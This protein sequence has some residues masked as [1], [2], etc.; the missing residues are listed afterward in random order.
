MRAGFTKLAG[1]TAGRVAALA[2]AWLVW[3]APAADTAR[4]P[5]ANL[6]QYGFL[7]LE[8]REAA[9]G[10]PPG[11]ARLADAA[12]TAAVALEAGDALLV[13]WQHP[14]PVRGLELV[15]TEP[16][17]ADAMQVE[18]WRGHWPDAGQ[19]GWMKLDDPFNGRWTLGQGAFHPH[20]SGLAFRFA[21]LTVRE[22]PGIRQTGAPFRK[23]YKL[24]LTGRQAVRLRRVAVRS[25]AV[26]RH[27][28]LRFE[29]DLPK[30]LPAHAAPRFE[31][32]NGTVQAVT[33]AAAKAAF[34]EV[35]YADAPDRL[36]PDRGLVIFRRGPERS[37][38]VFVDDVL[39]AGGLLVRDLG[40]FVSDAS[41]NLTFATWPGPGGDVWRQG[42]VAEQVAR[43]PEQTFAQAMAA[44]PA[45]PSAPCLLG[46]PNCR[47]EFVLEPDGDIVL[48]AGS[49]RSP[50]P[51]ADA[52]PW[53][54][55]DALRFEFST[56]ERPALN[57]RGTRVVE[58]SLQDGWL[59]V[60]RHAW[61]DDGLAWEQ[62]SVAA[63][64]LTPLAA[65]EA[66]TGAEPLVLGTRFSVTNT[67]AAARTAWLWL[68]PQPWRPLRLGADGT[69]LLVRPSDNV[70]RAGMVPVRGQFVSGGC[71][72]LD[73]GV[74]VPDTPDT[75]SAPPP[76]TS[77][78]REAVRYRV[79]LGPGEGHALDFLLPYVELL[80]A[81][82]MKA[83]RG[84]SFTNLHAAAVD[85]WRARV[86]RG[87][88]LETPEPW[89]ND[90]FKAHLW[91]VL[92]STD[93]DPETHHHQ[94]GAATLDYK[95]FLNETAMV[96]RA[97]DMR[98]EHAAA[99]AL[100][101][102]FLVN[103]G[104][105]GLPGNFRS[106]AGVFY[107][108][109]PGDPDPYTAQGYNLHHGWGLWAAS[110]HY[111]WTRDDAYLAAVTPRLIAGADWITCERQATLFK[112]PG[113]ARPVEYGLPP[114]GDLED[115]E[116]YLYWYAT[117][118][119]YHLGM[120]QAADV[121][122]RLAR[123]PG[124]APELARRLAREAERLRRDTG[125]F[126][127][128]VRA[129]VAES[130]ATSPVIQLR[131]DTWVPHMPARAYALT[132]RQE[133]WIREV[134]YGPLHLVNGDLLDDRHPFVDW[135]V[136][137]LEDNLLLCAESGF[138]VADPQ[139]DFFNHGGF[140]LQPMLLDLA[141]AY[142][143]RDQVPNF[144]RAFYNAAAAS[145]YPDTR[146]LAEWLPE[147]G[148]GGG[149]LYKT[150][151]ESKFIQ[152]LRQMLLFERGDTL[153][154]GL[155]VPRAW[156]ADGQRVKVERA[157]TWFGRLDL[158][159]TSRAAAGEIRAVV[160]LQ[161]TE[162]PRAL[163]LRLRHPAGQPLKSATVNGRSASVNAARQ[164][165]EL[166][167]GATAWEVIGRF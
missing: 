18:W 79:T 122:A 25:D 104:V 58:R 93:L 109:H 75:A 24:R 146:C 158:E 83:L 138:A 140:T 16:P 130:V 106:T 87:M 56:G 62:T 3:T 23:T 35:E 107:A 125:A 6:A 76:S 39:R 59:P 32:R 159:I 19:G 30:A 60:V 34:V 21:P 164:L 114:A 17:P 97:L 117:A 91:H 28:R 70:P 82:E 128:D 152:W 72:E 63:P 150:P 167:A 127:E 36:S 132:H 29:W 165:I 50:G 64:L 51:D 27:A 46:V 162:A 110:E 143:R 116:E 142:L 48:R 14:R 88:T 100:L 37:F 8:R 53:R 90:F 41:R 85:F 67:T 5:P 43:L 95:N 26:L 55:W 137:D 44:L 11:V 115:V 77:D 135:I 40:V 118:A 151:D 66:V 141:L 47:Q 94:H 105:K 13:E 145:L 33:T 92:I 84:L 163:G 54:R 134:L 108:A 22:A 99:R 10:L 73:L 103:Q 2:G 81:A 131:D 52:S 123:R 80:D 133:G 144:L 31:A 156:M 161:P 126:A 57:G 98:G 1:R 96:A 69:L 9:T 153:E 119:Y 157:A 71:G 111:L 101:E 136:H 78:A 74:F 42:T 15:F 20:G 121:V 148:K 45:K 86:T 120:K 68:A 38:S 102:P 166:P 154:L 147:L 113:G 61:T 4:L 65:F 155:G 149:P 112:L 124:V 139:A 89:L 49:L 12:N 160:R 7:R 129:S